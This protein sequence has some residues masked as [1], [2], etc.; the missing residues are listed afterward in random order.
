[1][2]Y[3]QNFSEKPNKW[4]IFHNFRDYENGTQLNQML[5]VFLN[6]FFTCFGTSG[7]IKLEYYIPDIKKHRHS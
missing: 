6:G 1:M 3:A 2:A 5:S 7:S 4:D